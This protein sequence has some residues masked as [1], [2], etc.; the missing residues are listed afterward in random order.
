MATVGAIRIGLSATSDKFKRDMHNA[1]KSVEG[2]VGKIASVKGAIVGGLFGGAVAAGVTKAIRSYAELDSATAKTG[3]VFGKSA[4]AV[5]ASSKRMAAQF[6]TVES[7]YLAAASSFGAAFKGA[8]SSQAE[9]ARV[10]DQLTQLGM[11]LAAFG[12]TS[13]EEAFGALSAAL[14]GEFDPLERFNVFLSADAVAAEAVAMGL[15]KSASAVDASAKKQA[16]LNLIL[17]QSVDAQGTLARESGQAGTMMRSIAGRIEQAWTQA[18]KAIAPLTLAVLDF[19]NSGL[20]KLNEWIGLNVTGFQ[21]L[22][23]SG[24]ES[25]AGITGPA[26]DV[27]AELNDNLGVL[28]LLAMGWHGLGIAIDAVI[29]GALTLIG[30]FAQALQDMINLIPG[31][32]VDLTSGIE[33]TLQGIDAHVAEKR[34]K[35]DAIWSGSAKRDALANTIKA[36][37]DAA[38]KATPEV[39]DLGGAVKTMTKEQVELNTAVSEL[40]DKLDKDIAGFGKS[41]DQNALADLKLKGAPTEQID[42]LQR[43]IDTLGNLDAFAK[44]KEDAKSLADEFKSP[45]QAFADFQSELT[46][47]RA[48]NLI[49]Q[50]DATAALGDKARS[51]FGDVFGMIDSTKSPLDKFEEQTAKIREALSAGAI[52]QSGANLAMNAAQKELNSS[53]GDQS[54]GAGALQAGSVEARRAILAFQQKGQDPNESTAKNTGALLV[55]TRSLPVK[56]GQEL[57]KS[58]TL[59][60]ARI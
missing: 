39:N 24:L 47:M 49:T 42:E 16:A 9:A 22:G 59:Q 46:K 5:I 27:N 14:R 17:K 37:G 50:D 2:F 57:A 30:A 13:N 43:K 51:L 15:A 7:E 31:M 33:S 35:I 3:V 10:G 18:G 19:V 45:T 4:D 58:A 12:D 32:D 53:G 29:G 36:A 55:E 56:I 44:L 52:D 1:G 48:S 34:A 20:V 25:L 60:V 26:A 54:P 28:D 23:T 38:S 40:R 21:Q 8:G 11:D 41:A 6:G